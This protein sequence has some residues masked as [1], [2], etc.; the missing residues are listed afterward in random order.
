[1]SVEKAYAPALERAL[2]H[3]MTHLDKAKDGPI[4]P[5][6]TTEQLRARLGR[7]LAEQGVEAMRV[8]DELVHDV[9]GGIM[10]NTTGRF[11]AW[12]MG[13]TLPAALAADWLTS[14]WDQNAASYTA[15]PA[16]AVIEEVAGEWLKDI[17]GLPP[18]ASFAFVI[19]RKWLM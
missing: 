7:P 3:A 12:V 1:M 6:A 17:F 11:Y 9:E 14:S 13:G 5:A 4:G 2:R 16:A 10:G 8:I 15:A 18:A 19:E